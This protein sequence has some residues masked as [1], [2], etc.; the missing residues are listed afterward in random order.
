MNIYYLNDEKREVTVRVLDTAYDP[1]TGTGDS[2]TKLAPCEGRMFTVH[3]PAG[4]IPYIKKWP[5]L[6]MISYVYPADLPQPI[7]QRE[8]LVGEQEG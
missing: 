5:A 4:A 8:H 2:F 7:G 3:L 1:I 6:I